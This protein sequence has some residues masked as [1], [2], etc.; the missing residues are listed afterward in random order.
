VTFGYYNRS[1]L[2]TIII[3]CS[4][5]KLSGDGGGSDNENGTEFGTTTSTRNLP[6]RSILAVWGTVPG[7]TISPY[8]PAY[9]FP[10]FQHVVFGEIKHRHNGDDDGGVVFDD[11]DE[12]WQ[13]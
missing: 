13:Q 3:F 10:S 9:K 11:D 8:S 7:S 5:L 2:T 1:F 12:I 6:N 4:S